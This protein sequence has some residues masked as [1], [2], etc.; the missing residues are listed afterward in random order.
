M[1]TTLQS[2]IRNLLPRWGRAFLWG[3]AG[4]V[5]AGSDS[6][7][8]RQNGYPSVQHFRG[9]DYG[10]HSVNHDV[11]VSAEG[12]VYVAN[13]DGILE[14]DGTS[15]RLLSMPGTQSPHSITTG[16]GGE[17]VVGA[18]G[19]FGRLQIDSLWNPVFHSLVPAELSGRLGQV[20]QLLV[21]SRATHI[22]T[23]GR[24]LSVRD[25]SVSTLTPTSPIQRAFIHQDS[26]YAVLWGRGLTRVLENDFVDLPTQGTLPKEE[27]QFSIP[28]N[29]STT[30]LGSS[31]GALFV[32]ASSGVVAADS[33]LGDQLPPAAIQT[34]LLMSDGALV[35]G[36]PGGRVAIRTSGATSF[37]MFDFRD[38]LPLG[39]INGMAEDGLGGLWLATSDGVARVDWRSSLSTPPPSAGWSGPVRAVAHVN[40]T[41]YLGTDVGLW[42]ADS[43]S[44][45]RMFSRLPGLDEPVTDLQAIDGDLLVASGNRLIVLPQ[46][47]PALSYDLSLERPIHAIASRLDNRGAVGI[48]M[49]EGILSVTRSAGRWAVRDRVDL[50]GLQPHSLVPFRGELWAGFSPAGVLRIQWA[51]DDS[52]AATLTRYGRQHGLPA[53]EVHPLVVGQSIGV[54]SRSGLRRFDDGNNRFQAE[55]PFRLASGPIAGDL[56]HIEVVGGDSV[57]VI[58]AE[59]A[60]IVPPANGAASRR[61][62]L[63]N[64][65]Q[66]LSRMAIH[67]VSCDPGPGDAVCWFAT[68][69]GLI[70]FAAATD[71][72]SR[73]GPVVHIRSVLAGTERVFGGGVAGRMSPPDLDL[74]IAKNQL[75]I[76]WSTPAGDGFD[77]VRYQYRLLGSSEE[78]SDWT[79]D[80]RTRLA[81]L[82]EGSYSFEVRALSGS[83]RTGPTSSA[84]FTIRP[85]WFRSL[86]A[87]TVYALL[88]VASIYLAGKS[89]ARFHVAQLGESNERLAKRLQAQTR[90]VE[91]QR[92]LLE[93]RNQ[94]LEVRNDQLTQQQ[95]QLE[96]RHEELRKS[97]QYIEDQA[98]QLAAQNRER[99]IQRKELERQ[100]R[101]LAKANEAL[102]ESSERAARYALDAQEATTAKSRFLANMSHEIRTPMNAIIGF[103]DLLAKKVDQPDL[104]RYINNIQSSGRSLLT[105]INDILDLS[106]VEAGKLDI[107]PQPMDLR[108]VIEDMPLMFGTKATTKGISFNASVQEGFPE[109]VVLDESRIR[110]ILINLLGNAVKF[111]DQGGVTLDVR[112]QSFD[113]DGPGQTTVLIRVEDT[114]IGI[115][116]ADQ[117]HIF[118]A[119]DQARGQSHAEFGG[120]GL[121][122]AITKKLVDLMDGAIYLESTPGKGSSFIVRLPRVR[123]AS[124]SAESVDRAMDPDRIRFAGNRVLVAEDDARN[125]ELIME[126]LQAAGLSCT[127]TPEGA[128]VL[129]KLDAEPFDL[130]LLDLH[131]PDMDGIELTAAIRERFGS[132]IPIIGFSASVL[133]DKAEE[134]RASVNDFLAKPVAVSE[135]ISLLVNYLPYQELEESA[136]AGTASTH[137]L[138]LT[139]APQPL[140]DILR[141]LEPEFKE[142]LH[143]QT[144]NEMESFGQKVADLG[145]EHGFPPA[146]Q[147]GGQVADTA[148]HFDLGRLLPLFPDFTKLIDA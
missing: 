12:M 77:V 118:G 31:D 3:L 13:Q 80:T 53:G 119:F 32:L 1:H 147:W 34:S 137:P 50:P 42:R 40:G 111:T 122:L 90:E 28:W 37:R 76:T 26:L 24:I 138:A 146:E 30:V 62:M 57:L 101:L 123:T 142:L 5:L 36:L 106:K 63:S 144:V 91:Q 43:P 55:D 45:P 129:R 35:L 52:S 6:A 10:H 20:N 131:L 2:R 29:D 135:L 89:L 86:W 49:D 70:R 21:S 136:P 126:M 11:A 81:G 8:A 100:R 103:T 47:D 140:L 115:A 121:G 15:W 124:A 88:F 4:L 108:R 61:L 96:I 139:T 54:W 17:I 69:Q 134:F 67:Q 44:L 7:F 71:H 132:S 85:P 93:Q 16:L 25:D 113:N 38:G 130:V 116:E 148:H 14:Y 18:S 82:S 79:S 99:D 22:V 27:I 72:S 128:E 41:L 110:Q 58:G 65:L 92:Q 48:G 33:S 46:G 104:L 141:G 83:G 117:E 56:R 39:D 143:R 9:F 84:T 60:G 73:L 109:R 105:L 94:D 125:Q 19:E 68:D 23:A 74:P 120:T 51:A 75:T 145:R 64:G 78:W 95:R 112:A 114:G 87:F 66:R 107:D 98:E 133:G 59:V 127:C 102:E 97:K